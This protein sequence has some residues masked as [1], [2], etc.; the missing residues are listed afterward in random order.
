M[1][2]ARLPIIIV[3]SGIA[4][5]TL[6]RVLAKHRI[7]FRVVEKAS[8]SRREGYGI[9]LRA[10]ATQPLCDEI[11]MDHQA[12]IAACAADAGINGHGLID[13]VLYDLH[14]L[15]PLTK[16]EAAPTGSPSTS[17]F[18]ANRDR[19]RTTLM[20]EFDVKFD[21]S[22]EWIDK[23]EMPRKIKARLSNG[24]LIEGCLLVGADGVYSTVRS[25]TMPG[26]DPVIMPAA[27]ASGMRRL[28]RSQFETSFAPY[29]RGSNA[30][31]AVAD[32]VVAGI[33]VVDLTESSAEIFWTFIRPFNGHD[34]SLFRANQDKSG[35]SQLVDI[36][37]SEVNGLGHVAE[38]YRQIF[39]TERMRHDEM[40]NWLM[41]S[42]QI[43]TAVLLKE[44]ET[45]VA[46]IG[47]AAHA[48]PFFA[49]EGG[50]HALL[51]GVEM[52][53]LIGGEPR[54]LLECVGSF[55]RQ[56]N[57]RWSAAVAGSIQGISRLT[58]SME[59]WRQAARE[60]RP[61]KA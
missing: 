2:A 8:P 43:P 9:S 26:H 7:P 13:P 27:I 46:I 21:V 20:A 12:F 31:L 14:T 58:R 57:S 17:V 52:G 10:W 53:R 55:Y 48:M 39:D 35:A 54:D 16:P 32:Y 45:G 61:S 18:R 11:G 42:V 6:A 59:E 5:L 3:G 30:M 29:L 23:S 19:I 49:G 50:N 22:L 41:R 40:F 51:D 44:A 60:S 1:T 36:M 56:A 25:M 33:T 37:R 4:G 38:P 15:E 28:T 34:D 47:D 24:E